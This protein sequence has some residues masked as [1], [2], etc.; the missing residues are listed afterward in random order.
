MPSDEAYQA[1]LAELSKLVEAWRIH[2]EVINRAVSLL[3]EEVWGF[4]KRL[5]KDD[6]AREVRQGQIDAAL[7]VLIDGQAQIK[8]RQNIRIGIELLI[9]LAGIAFFIGRSL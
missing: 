1:V 7:K 9:V 5:D 6:E 3:N 4:R 8:R 2:R